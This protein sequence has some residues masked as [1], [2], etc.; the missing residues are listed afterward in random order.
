MT[1][2]HFRTHCGFEYNDDSVLLEVKDF[3]LNLGGIVHGGLIATML[4]HAGAI[5]IGITPEDPWVTI[6]LN[7]NYLSFGK[8]G[9]KLHTKT[10]MVRKGASVSVTNVEL[11]N[12]SGKLIA[13]ST[14]TYKSIKR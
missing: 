4:D 14:N 6:T 10:H 1:D 12:Q 9:D 5:P 8:L 3:H 7:V 11:F 13:T 2:I